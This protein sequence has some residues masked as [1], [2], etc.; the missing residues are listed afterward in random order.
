[1]RQLADLDLQ[2]DVVEHRAPREQHVALEH[3]ADA[4]GGTVDALAAISIDPLVAGSRPPT[5]FSSVLLPQ[6]LGPTTDRNSPSRMSK[7]SGFSDSTSPSA[8][9]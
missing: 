1:M 9:R 8:V 6:P 7:S 2:H 4:L 5:S 3:D